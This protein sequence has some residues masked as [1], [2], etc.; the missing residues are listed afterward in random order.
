MHLAPAASSKGKKPKKIGQI[1]LPH[2]ELL[3]VLI[4]VRAGKFVAKKSKLPISNKFLWT[5]SECVLNWMRTTK[6]HN[7]IKE[8]HSHDD[9][10]FCYVPSK[11]NPA[12]LPTY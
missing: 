4:G 2:L 3:A 9:M 8:I 7:R 12:D 1:T 11:K 6:P 5:D 10:T